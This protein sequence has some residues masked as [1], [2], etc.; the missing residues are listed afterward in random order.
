MSA[1]GL[2]ESTKRFDLAAQ[3]VPIMLPGKGLKGPEADTRMG[4][5]TADSIKRLMT[6]MASVDEICLRFAHVMLDCDQIR[7][8]SI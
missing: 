5:S 2:R 7:P 8:M 4:K 3:K 6:S 1:F